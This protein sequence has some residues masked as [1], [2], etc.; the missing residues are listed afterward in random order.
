M[1][2]EIL[3]ENFD[4]MSKANQEKFIK[5]LNDDQRDEYTRA[6]NLAMGQLKD[7]LEE[8]FDIFPVNISQKEIMQTADDLR[9]VIRF[10]A[11][12]A[13]LDQCNF[14]SEEIVIS[15]RVLADSRQEK[16]FLTNKRALALADCAASGK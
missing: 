7:F 13:S 14:Q 11:I 12:V 3:P 8:E 9:K 2:T 10:E 15:E 5:N 1:G 4:T 16:H 6:K